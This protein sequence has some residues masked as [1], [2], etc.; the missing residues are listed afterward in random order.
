MFSMARLGL[1]TCLHVIAWAAMTM[2]SSGCLPTPPCVNN[3]HARCIS[4]PVGLQL[5]HSVAQSE[6]LVH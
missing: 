1:N 2:M 4:A 3:D 5:N 6:E